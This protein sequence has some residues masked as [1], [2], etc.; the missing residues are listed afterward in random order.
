MFSHFDMCMARVGYGV[1]ALWIFA[2][3]VP[4]VSPLYLVFRRHCFDVLQRLA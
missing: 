3:S 2:A 4:L 1:Y